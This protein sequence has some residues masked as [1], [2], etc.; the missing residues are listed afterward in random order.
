MSSHGPDPGTERV[1]SP[2]AGR[3]FRALRSMA[4]IS[5]VDGAALMLSDER[6]HLRAVGG[7]TS[8]GLELEYVQQL[9]RTGPAHE[10][11]ASDHPIAVP[12]LSDRDAGYARLADR[13]APV[14]SVLS[15][16]IR[17]DHRPIGALN[18]Y[19]CTPCEWTSHQIAVGQDLAEAM[20]ELLTVLSR[21]GHGPAAAG[22]R[23][24]TAGG[25]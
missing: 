9:E 17:L 11:V 1:G 13:A 8:E 25:T 19:R 20:A 21:R 14:R 12:D 18:L 3:L 10:S 15:V 2:A 6:G 16:P 4:V 24:S 23:Q 7:S 5:R 22:R